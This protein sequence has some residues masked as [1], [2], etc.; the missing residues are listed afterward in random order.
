MAKYYDTERNSPIIYYSSKRHL[1]KTDLAKA[2]G[3]STVTMHSYIRNPY[4]I[5]L[6]E[7]VALAGLLGLPIEELIYLLVRNKPRVDSSQNKDMK[8]S[9]KW[10]LEDIRERNKDEEI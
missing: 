3:V 6:S 7:L 4:L 10:F 8:N 9:A 5:R 1:S 2:L